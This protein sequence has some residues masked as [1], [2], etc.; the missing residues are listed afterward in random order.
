MGFIGAV[1][2]KRA[3]TRFT[4]KACKSDN[5][6]SPAASLGYHSD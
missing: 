6:H 3:L 1:V 5:L 2:A 4:N